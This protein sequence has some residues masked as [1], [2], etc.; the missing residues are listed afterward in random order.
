M[1]QGKTTKTQLRFKR[2]QTLNMLERKHKFQD[3][4]DF[5]VKMAFQNTGSMSFEDLV[6]NDELTADNLI[7]KYK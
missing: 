7:Q 6:Y 2:L 1:K 4:W 5:D 3:N